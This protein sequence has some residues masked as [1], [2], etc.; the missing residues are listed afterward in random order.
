MDRTSWIQS[1]GLAA[2]GPAAGSAVCE[3]RALPGAPCCTL[4]RVPS[5]AVTIRSRGAPSRHNTPLRQRRRLMHRTS[6]IQSGLLAIV[7]GAALTAPAWAATPDAWITTKT[8]LALLTTEGVS[9]TAIKVDTVL[10]PQS[11]H[12]VMDDNARRL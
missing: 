6:W 10:G 4:R 5:G 1:S 7:L 11:T 9:G 3:R 12:Q 2:A 8:K